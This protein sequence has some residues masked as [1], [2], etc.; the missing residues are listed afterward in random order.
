MPLIL[1]INLMRPTT[2]KMRPV[3][4]RPVIRKESE[5]EKNEILEKIEESKVEIEEPLNFNKRAKRLENIEL[6]EKGNDDIYEWKE[7]F[8]KKRPL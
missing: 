4:A 2:A 1:L 3:T 7:L 8:S 5:E 6:I